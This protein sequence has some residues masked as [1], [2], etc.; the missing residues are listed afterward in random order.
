MIENYGKGRGR[1]SQGLKGLKEMTRSFGRY[2]D[3]LSLSIETKK[4]QLCRQIDRTKFTNYSLKNYSNFQKIIKEEITI[5]KRIEELQNKSAISIQK[6]FRG[7]LVRK[8]TFFPM[9]QC[10]RNILNESITN[11]GLLTNHLFY[12]QPETLKVRNKQAIVKIQ[13]SFRS[14]KKRKILNIWIEV[15]KMCIAFKNDVK[16]IKSAVKMLLSKSMIEELK[17]AR[18]AKK[19]LFQIR[20]KIAI[21]TVKCY[22]QKN[23]LTLS[24]LKER[25]QKYKNFLLTESDE[26]QKTTAKGSKDEQILDKY[27]NYN[28]PKFQ[29]KDFP[30]YM[31]DSKLKLKTK[32]FISIVIKKSSVILPQVSTSPPFRLKTLNLHQ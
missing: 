4:K 11:L 3:K 24:I 31:K 13:N 32:K 15:H 21:L 7:Y 9:L 25:I 20:R 23:F 16:I 29:E 28:F 8:F 30:D 22:F 26:V 5:R 18:A 2:R 14:Y 19:K 6:V 12:S 27:F 17:Q 10:C 1:S